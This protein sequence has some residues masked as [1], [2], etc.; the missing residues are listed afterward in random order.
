MKQITNITADSAQRH[1]IL[2]GDKTIVLTLKFLEVASIWCFDIEYNGFS[3]YGFKL[4]LNVQH[5]N[6][7][8]LPFDFI[9]RDTTNTGIDPFQ[10]DDFFSG[11]IEMYILEADDLLGL[12]GYSVA[13]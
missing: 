4:S 10:I 2:V 13:L 6:N 3:K 12:R 8:N 11:R 5:L 1:T 9:I 7:Y